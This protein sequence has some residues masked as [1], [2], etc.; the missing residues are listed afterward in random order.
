MTAECVPLGDLFEL[1]RRPVRV[2]PDEAYREIGLRSF[3]RGV[4]HKE[5]L[6]GRE[7]RGKR[8]FWIEPGDLLVS[9]V[10]AWEGAVAVAG[11]AER[12]RIG[13]H[14]FMTWTPRTDDVLVDYVWH[15]LLSDRGME[16]LRAASPG[17]A[18]RNRTLSI[19]NFQR[20]LVPLPDRASQAQVVAHL[21]HVRRVAS[22]GSAKVHGVDALLHRYIESTDETRPLGELLQEHYELVEIEPGETYARA[23][24]YNKGQG[25]F[26]QQPFRGGD[27]SYT[28]CYR[29][30]VDTV[31]LSRLGA[32]EGG[33]AVVDQEFAGFVV[34]K[35]F[36]TFRPRPGVDVGYLRALTTWSGLWQQMAAGSPGTPARRG[37]M[38]VPLF[39]STVV[40]RHDF[41]TQQLIGRLAAFRIEVLKRLARRRQLAAALLPAA[42]NE[43][44][45]SSC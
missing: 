14:R 3:G 34:S 25:L 17:S 40:P 22:A 15:Y 4:F 18:G 42:R 10:F 29:L 35:E 21:D 26:A 36:P 28:T 37:R 16:Q 1:Q 43:V 9:N 20:V 41:Q 38:S 13:S 33:V 7:L 23:G 27:T 45:A 32:F 6:G 19:K 39:L 44:F 5:D 2:R 8:V 24:V 31:V 30:A 12:T 11:T